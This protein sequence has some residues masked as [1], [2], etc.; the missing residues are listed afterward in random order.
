VPSLVNLAGGRSV[1]ASSILTAYLYMAEMQVRSRATLLGPLSVKPPKTS[2][3]SFNGRGHFEYRGR[4]L[5]NSA[6]GRL[7]LSFF[8]SMPET[9]AAYVIGLKQEPFGAM[10]MQLF[11]AGGGVL[12]GTRDSHFTPEANRWYD[13]RID[14]DDNGFVTIIRARFRAHGTAEPPVF[15]IDAVGTAPS[16]LT[17]GRIGVW[18]ARGTDAFVDDIIATSSAVEQIASAVTFFNS[19]TRAALD[20]AKLALFK[21]AGTLQ[22]RIT[23]NVSTVTL[24]GVPFAL[25]APSLQSDGSNLYTPP[26]IA[27]DGMHTLAVRAG[28]ADA[29]LRFLVDQ[30]PPV[31]TL[32]A[33]NAP[34]ADGTIYDTNDR[35]S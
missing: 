17:G 2:F 4:F 29:S 15:S 8:S 7:G 6:N 30:K 32:K 3:A 23:G 14:A 21:G 33:N 28:D 24:D 13:F 11:A 1:S 10:T 18:A 5:R 20:P 27:V 25:G 26:S 16:H 35:Q 22:L 31:V 19:A 12:T 34:L 9:L